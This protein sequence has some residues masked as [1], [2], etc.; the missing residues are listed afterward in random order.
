MS[1]P[2]DPS[3]LRARVI[4]VLGRIGACGTTEVRLELLGFPRTQILHCVK[5]SVRVGDIINI[6][7]NEVQDEQDNWQ[8][9][10]VVNNSKFTYH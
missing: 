9:S 1:Q 5:G 6:K 7:D 3:I 4:K 2:A 10:N 8:S